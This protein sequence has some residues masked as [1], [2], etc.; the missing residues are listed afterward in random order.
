ML[1]LNELVPQGSGWTLIV[2]NSD[3]VRPT[4]HE[5]IKVFCGSVLHRDFVEQWISELKTLIEQRDD[6]GALAHMA[7]IVPEYRPSERWRTA[8]SVGKKAAAVGA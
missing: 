4:C 8:L 3:A 7:E 5:K 6:I 1:D 2:A